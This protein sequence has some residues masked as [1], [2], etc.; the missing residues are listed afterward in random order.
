MAFRRVTYVPGSNVPIYDQNAHTQGLF[1]AGALPPEQPPLP[2]GPPPLIP[3]QP[4]CPY[5]R[6]F[7]VDDC[8]ACFP[9]QRRNLCPAVEC[10]DCVAEYHFHCVEFHPCPR[11]YAVGAYC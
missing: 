11:L 5:C 3:P 2:P 7:L 4:Y 8:P 9:L 1:T 10:R 6:R